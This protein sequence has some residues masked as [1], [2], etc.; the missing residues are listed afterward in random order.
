MFIHPSA[1]QHLIPGDPSKEAFHR[2]EFLT[3]KKSEAK[4][5]PVIDHTARTRV[6]LLRA[7]VTAGVGRFFV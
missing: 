3:A 2:E 1:L 5:Q 4:A 6:T 7:R